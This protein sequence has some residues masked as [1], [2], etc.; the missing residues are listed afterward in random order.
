MMQIKENDSKLFLDCMRG[1]IMSA[2]LQHRRFIYH[3]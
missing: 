2:L 3:L 1:L